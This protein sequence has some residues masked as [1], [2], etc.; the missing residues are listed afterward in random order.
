MANFHGT[1]S[2]GQ[3]NGCA[4]AH[5]LEPDLATVMLYSEL[6]QKK[7][8]QSQPQ[9]PQS[10]SIL[11]GVLERCS[12]YFKA[13]NSLV[14]IIGW[15]KKELD[16][17][18]LQSLATSAFFKDCQKEAATYVENFRGNGFYTL[19]EEDIM[20]VK[21]RETAD[22]TT[23]FKLVPPNTLLYSRMAET[24]QR[25]FHDFGSPLQPISGLRS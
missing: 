7:C 21:G 24:F 5:R 16:M 19:L 6:R 20:V 9:I 12:N 17:T 22:G 3:E 23:T 13:V 1:I 25:E 4:S 18:E 15:K 14:R 2:I 11:M 8:L 10:Q